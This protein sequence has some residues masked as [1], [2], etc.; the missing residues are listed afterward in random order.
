[1]SGHFWFDRRRRWS[2]CGRSFRSPEA[3]RGG[4]YRRVLS[5]IIYIQ[6]ERVAVEGRAAVYMGRRKTLYNRLRA[7]VAHGRVR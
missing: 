2:G 4:G 6:E 1:M 5:G 3:S 7:L